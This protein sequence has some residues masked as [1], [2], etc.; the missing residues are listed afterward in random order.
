ML[1]LLRWKF[2]N[3]NISYAIPVAF[4]TD[5]FKVLFFHEIRIKVNNTWVI[6]VCKLIQMN[7]SQSLTSSWICNVFICCYQ[8]RNNYTSTQTYSSCLINKRHQEILIIIINNI[9]E[10]INFCIVLYVHRFFI[11]DSSHCFFYSSL[12]ISSFRSLFCTLFYFV[13]GSVKDRNLKRQEP[14]Y[15]DKMIWSKFDFNS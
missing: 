15:C 3:E 10:W 7:W 5:S 1:N 13:F 9:K 11:I 14:I 2:F 12:I 6:I 4:F 8:Y